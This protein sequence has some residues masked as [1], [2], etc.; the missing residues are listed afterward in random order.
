M[1]NNYLKY[2]KNYLNHNGLDGFIFFKRDQF[3]GDFC[4]DKTDAV[5]HISGFSGSYAVLLV[6]KRDVYIFTDSIE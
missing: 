2:I 6:T 4:F 5:K 1:E 3:G